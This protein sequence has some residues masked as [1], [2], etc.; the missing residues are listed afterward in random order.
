MKKHIVVT[1]IAG[2]ARTRCG[3]IV[4]HATAYRKEST[5]KQCRREKP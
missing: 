3:R 1:F 4:E 2:L 5:C